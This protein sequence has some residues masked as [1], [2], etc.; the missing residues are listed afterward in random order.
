MLEVVCV[1]LFTGCHHATNVGKQNVMLH[2]RQGPFQRLGH[3][4]V[5]DSNSKAP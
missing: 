5:I 4:E 3:T 2:L 1:S